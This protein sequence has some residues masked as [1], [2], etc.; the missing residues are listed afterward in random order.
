MR[1]PFCLLVLA[2]G[3]AVGAQGS[4]DLV[5][6]GGKIVTVDD[7]FGE[8]EALAAVG[9]R[10]VALGSDAD[11][12]R[13][14]GARTRVLE[15]EGRT[16]VPGFIEGH[17]HFT[18]IGEALQVLDLM[19]VDSWDEIVA[20]VA[21]AAREAEPGAWILGRG[22]HQEKW[23]EP[24]P[25]AVAGFPRHD[26]LSAVSPD[27]PVRLVHASGHA[28]FV[29]QKAMQ[30]AGIDAGTESPEGGE[31]LHDESGQPIGVL[32]ERA[33]G[34]VGA[35]VRGADVRRDPAARRARIEHAIELAEREC[36]ANGVTSF[37]D[38]GS[39]FAEVDVMRDLA[40]RGELDVR[41]WVMIRESNQRLAQRLPRYRMVGIGNHFLTV[42][43]LK[44][45][46]DG[47]LG[48]RGAWLLEPYADAPDSTGLA[49]ASVESVTETAQLALRHGFQMCVHAIGD[50][51]N[52]EVL[53][54][55]ERVAGP[56]LAGLRWRVEHTQHVHPDD[57]ARF[58]PLG[59]I[60][61]M[62]AVHCTSDAPYVIAR[63][64]EER[65]RSGAYM[66]RTLIDSGA[67]VTNGTDAPV[68]D[69]DPL[70]SFRAAATRVMADGRT[71]FAEQCM[72]RREALQSYTSWA[73]SAAFEDDVKGTLAPGMLADIA[74]LSHDILTVPDEQLA[75][76]VVEATIVGSVVRYQ[77]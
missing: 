23:V 35:I 40:L 10:V 70:A 62:Q 63:L 28:C 8:V 71:F 39:S 47:A 29:N 45:S 3:G 2:L 68:E 58:A 18:G 73:A 55:F 21:A 67:L 19:T 56:Q 46:I 38:A 12:E 44:R 57:L 30:L 9:D 14:I 75:D 74:V 60:A 42:R 31:I 41:L 61:S 50:R 25:D 48:P 26:A 69:I 33:Q 36:L 6:R 49:T 76:A 32:S 7:R 15:L 34:L 27:N 16:A 24:P 43:A 53:D 20:M 66:W 77:R 4:A 51:A 72:T 11:I 65:A 37:Q 54:L 1:S 13:W 64:G 5:L 17:A 59:V 22:W 52:R